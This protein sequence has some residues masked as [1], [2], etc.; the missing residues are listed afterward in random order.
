MVNVKDMFYNLNESG[1]LYVLNR[2]FV[3]IYSF[4]IIKKSAQYDEKVS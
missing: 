2:L 3:L 4:E 1:K